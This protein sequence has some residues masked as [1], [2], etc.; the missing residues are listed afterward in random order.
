MKFWNEESQKSTRN[1]RNWV[2]GMAET[3]FN[4]NYVAFHFDIEVH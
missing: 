4:I 1:E 3:G 2:F